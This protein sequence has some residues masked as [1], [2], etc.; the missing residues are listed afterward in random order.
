MTKRNLLFLSYSSLLLA[1]AILLILVFADNLQASS[2]LQ[3]RVFYL[4]LLLMGVFCA[5]ALFGFLKST[6]SVKGNIGGLAISVAGPAALAMIVVIG[7]FYLIPRYEFFDVTIRAVN[8]V[9]TPVYSDRKARVKLT[10]PTGVREADFTRNGE[11][12]IK[13]LP[14]SLFNSKQKILV[15]IYYY[16]QILPGQEYTLSLD[17]IEV[18][19]KENN[20][21]PEGILNKKKAHLEVLKLLAPYKLLL[22]NNGR[23]E[24]DI[25]QYFD[26]S[27][28][29]RLKTID[30]H[31]KIHLSADQKYDLFD[32]LYEYT[33]E[34][35]NFNGKSYAELIHESAINFRRNVSIMSQI[36]SEGMDPEIQRELIKI[37]RAQFV[38]M[39]ASVRPGG[40]YDDYF[41]DPLWDSLAFETKRIHDDNVLNFFT[42]F[43][44]F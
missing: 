19:L 29:E 21:T 31:E 32:V 36:D 17:V 28:L 44:D 20:G 8:D 9:G 14:Y 35:L 40:D 13:G 6:A 1:I 4:S 26:K 37:S 41:S 18:Q 42:E 34:Q 7:G 33:P 11:A 24:I 25:D 10:L 22:G 23:M 30:V 5:I 38:I 43:S 3:D 12:T 27:S 39:A 15:D 2:L 16:D